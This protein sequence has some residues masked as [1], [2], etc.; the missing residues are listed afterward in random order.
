MIAAHAV[1]SPSR[2]R[3]R[4]ANVN[5]ARRRPILSPRRPKQKLPHIQGPAR[6]VPSHEVRVHALKALG[7][8][9]ASRQNALAKA[10]S[11][12]LDLILESLQHV[13][14]RS[15]GH[16]A[17]SP[18]GVLVCWGARA[19]EETRL[20]QQNERVLGV[21]SDSHRLFRSGNLLKA[22]AQMY[23]C[24]SEAF[25]SFPRNRPVQRIIHLEDPG[26]VAVYLQSA[27]V[28]LR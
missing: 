3:G 23:R 27:F 22:S 14:F 15:V 19:I 8:K 20:S 21:I 24:C 2:R 11:E 6:D 9:D 10:W 16:M 1:H 28:I 18:G 5:F 7:R 17:I 25:R 4:G 12:S 26:A 13:F